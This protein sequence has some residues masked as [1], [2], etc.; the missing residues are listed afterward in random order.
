MGHLEAALSSLGL[1]FS[2]ATPTALLTQRLTD[3]LRQKYP[4]YQRKKQSSLKQQIIDALN[5]AKKN[6]LISLPPADEDKPVVEAGDGK[7]ESG[8]ETEG[9]TAAVEHIPATGAVPASAVASEAQATVGSSAA[10]P[11]KKR[12]RPA[13]FDSHYGGGAESNVNGSEA[14]AGK[15]TSASAFFAGSASAF[16]LPQAL[17]PRE[18]LSDV[19]G[20]D[21]ILEELSRLVLYPLLHPEMFAHLGVEPPRGVLLYGPPGVGKTLLARAL[22]GE[23]ADKG[24]Y[25]RQVEGSDIV[26]GI[27]GESE[28]RLRMLFDDAMRH[29]P[30]ILFIDELDSIAPRRG[31]GGGG[32]GRGMDR[33]ILAT[34][35]SCMDALGLPP[36]EVPASQEK[37]GEELRG[38]DDHPSGLS[39]APHPSSSSAAFPSS[40]SSVEAITGSFIQGG[41][42]AARSATP[43]IGGAAGGGVIVLAATDKPESVDSSLRRAGRFDRELGIPIPDEKGRLQILKMVTQGMR[44]V[45]SPSLVLSSASEGEADAS[46]NGK[47]VKQGQAEEE[48]AAS[49]LLSDLARATPGFVGAD[50]KAV[51]KEAALSA[52][53]RFLLAAKSSG[54]NEAAMSAAATAASP[55]EVDGAGG[56]PA[57]ADT[58]GES[59]GDGSGKLADSSSSALA[60][61]SSASSS[62][63][64]P[65]FSQALLDSSCYISR[66]DLF[67]AL[68]KVQPAALREGF[69]TIPNV[70][71]KDVGALSNV[72]SELDMAILQPLRHPELFKAMGLRA[73][74]GVLLYGPPGCGKTLLAKAIASETHA[75]FIS[76]KGP[77]LL[78][79]YVGESERAVRQLFARARASAPCVVFFDELDA[80]A[81][82]RGGVG[83]GGGESGGG[84]GV[85]ERVVNQLLTELDGLDAKRDVF[86]LAATNRPDIIDPAMLRPGRLEKLLYVPLP[87]PEDRFDILRTHARHT[88]LSADVDLKAIAMD[89]R[90]RGFSGADLASLVREAS[91]IALQGF[92]ASASA[93]MAAG[94]VAFPASGSPPLQATMADFLRAFSKVQPSV[95]AADERA[96]A[97]LGGSLR[98]MRGHINEGGGKG[99]SSGS[100]KGATGGS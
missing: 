7:A 23:C 60:F 10:R 14:A 3:S 49:S 22:G 98:S 45:S 53:S 65:A 54:K 31:D 68:K 48:D 74:A 58:Q 75:N 12:K 52:I 61:S 18:R 91:T 80:L 21:S 62:L 24:V 82:R 72:R 55:M 89:A 94:T 76:V 19:G 100:S 87:T 6:G 5:A 59:K 42:Q 79:K 20:C 33:R 90:C 99:D 39:G 69:A 36:S 50:L 56:G 97:S 92:L 46:K 70:T 16:S 26:A 4:A 77:E 15:A 40:S 37:E 32:G 38:S 71:W 51:A 95:S 13:D 64:S 44:I 1:N 41:A 47:E 28:A 29:A 25:F 84:S 63:F 73:P 78:D 67:G 86:V 83:T 9:E 35:A 34:L 81:P 88:P 93:S 2:N 85:S 96:Y 8:K 27:S 43:R 57:T 66:D 17:K 11:P 30:A